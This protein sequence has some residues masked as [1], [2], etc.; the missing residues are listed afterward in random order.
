[1]WRIKDQARRWHKAELLRNSKKV[2][3]HSNKGGKNEDTHNAAQFTLDERDLQYD[4]YLD[5]E[6]SLETVGRVRDEFIG[7]SFEEN[8]VRL[9]YY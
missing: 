6:N 4:D 8:V 1:M 5:S 7:D 9:L 2:K 3:Q